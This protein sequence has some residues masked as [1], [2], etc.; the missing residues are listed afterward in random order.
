MKRA[1]LAAALLGA[2]LLSGCDKNCQ[3]TCTR[4]YAESECHVVIP[5]VTPE[6][7]Q[8]ECES[9][10]ESALTRAGSMGNYNP[11]NNPDPENP[12]VL[13]DFNER[14][15]A[16]WMNCVW[17]VECPQLDPVTGGVCAPI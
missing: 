13:E 1:M 3:N 9:A 4:I 6:A 12:P 7:L 14:Q 17:D 11:Y 10:C 15:V 2:A 16:A 8:R 5:G